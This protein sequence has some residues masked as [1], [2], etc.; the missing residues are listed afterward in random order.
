[1]TVVPASLLSASRWRTT[2][3]HRAACSPRSAEGVPRVQPA[4][5]DANVEHWWIG[6]VADSGAKSEGGAIELR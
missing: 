6:E 1:M 2:L 4:L 5:E 3:R